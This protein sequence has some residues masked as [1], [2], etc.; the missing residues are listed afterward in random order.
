MKVCTDSCLFGAYV[1]V[2]NAARILDVGTGTGLLSLMVAQRSDA[3]ID[4]VEINTEA[5]EQVQE[6]FNS[7]PWN[8]RFSL[9]PVSLQ[10]FATHNQQAYDVILSNP[11]FF[12]SSLKSGNV[13]K[14]TAKHTGELLFEAI[15][16]FA[17]SHLTVEGKLYLLL[18]PWEARHFAGLAENSGLHLNKTLAVYT[19]TYGQC[20]RHIQTYSFTPGTSVSEQLIDIREADR[21]TYTPAFRELLKEYYLIF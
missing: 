8:G 6:N 7:S 13:A 21:V 16:S 15:L 20:I 5:A 3:F 19:Y 9:K 4:A 10:E 11:P 17:T 2:Q 12:L 14:D 18:P 1:D